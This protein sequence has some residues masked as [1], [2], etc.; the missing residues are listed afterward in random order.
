MNLI[1]ANKTSFMQYLLS[2]ILISWTQISSKWFCMRLIKIEKAKKIIENN[3][4]AA[5]M[6]SVSEEHLPRGVD[7]VGTMWDFS[8][9]TQNFLRSCT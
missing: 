6:S 1:F 8:H 3:V 9:F 4:S 7:A 5:I 2:E